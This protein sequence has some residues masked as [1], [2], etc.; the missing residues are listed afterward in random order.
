MGDLNRVISFLGS[1]VK[2][3]MNETVHEEWSE[4]SRSR[5]GHDF[6]TGWTFVFRPMGYG[7]DSRL[8]H[9]HLSLHCHFDTSPFASWIYIKES[10]SCKSRVRFWKIGLFLCPRSTMLWECCPCRSANTFSLTHESPFT[11]HPVNGSSGILMAPDKPLP[12]SVVGDV[13]QW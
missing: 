12:L 3:K 8:W 11:W 2:G 10:R 1:T 5:P 4:E 13:A 6:T 7:F 9:F